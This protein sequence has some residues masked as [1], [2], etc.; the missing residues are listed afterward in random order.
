[1]DGEREGWRAVPETFL[2]DF[3]VDAGQDTERR[4][5]TSHAF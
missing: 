2:D 3:G 5:T 4:T 1:M